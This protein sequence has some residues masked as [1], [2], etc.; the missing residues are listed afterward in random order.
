M[1]KGERKK[2]K[3]NEAGGWGAVEGSANGKVFII[4]QDDVRT[5]EHGESESS[6]L[7]AKS[8]V[9]YVRHLHHACVCLTSPNSWSWSVERKSLKDCKN[10]V[11]LRQTC[12]SG[13]RTSD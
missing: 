11:V 12:I 13:S 4:M 7:C 1:S 10:V 5:D 3:E 9:A 8:F 2:Q 6:E